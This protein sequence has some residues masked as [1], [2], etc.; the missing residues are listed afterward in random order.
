MTQAVQEALLGVRAGFARETLG[1]QEVF[2]RALDAMSRPGRLVEVA[3]EAQLPSDAHRAAGLVLLALLD[4]DTRLWTSP[5]VERGDTVRHL[6]FHTGCQVVDEPAHADFAWVARAD[7]LPALDA[8]AMGSDEWPDRSTTIVLQVAAM[9]DT[10]GWRLTGPGIRGETR[11][12][13]AGLGAAFAAQWQ[14]M[15]AR[16]PRGVDVLLTCGTH[17]AALPRST[18][19]AE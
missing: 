13:V 5:S 2:R 1:A 8:F 17:V 19:L 15:R 16:Y 12:H 10:R 4:S 3:C 9:D 11:L 7:E 14:A 6:R 18:Q